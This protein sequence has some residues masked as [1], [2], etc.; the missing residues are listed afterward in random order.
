MFMT[1]EL[2]A[3]LSW[4]TIQLN[5]NRIFS[6]VFS[7]VMLLSC[8]HAVRLIW[9]NVY[10]TLVELWVKIWHRDYTQYVL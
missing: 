2:L 9:D 8:I 1:L 6:T 5:I 10:G 4:G 3:S 7:R